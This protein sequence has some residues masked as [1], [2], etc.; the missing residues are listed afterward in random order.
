LL[1]FESSNQALY[2]SG[3][4]IGAVSLEAAMFRPVLSKDH[5]AE[6]VEVISVRH[7]I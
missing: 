2:A 4:D 5:M 3:G 1:G 6:N 7:N